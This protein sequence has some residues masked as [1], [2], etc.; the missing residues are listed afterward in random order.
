M[1]GEHL[2]CIVNLIMQSLCFGW[3]QGMD[4]RLDE[5]VASIA[6]PTEANARTVVGSLA[7]ALQVV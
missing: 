2:C 7:V 3:N 1:Q 4:A 6:P 5:F